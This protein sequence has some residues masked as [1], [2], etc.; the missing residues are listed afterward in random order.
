M[1][2]IFFLIIIFLFS[3]YPNLCEIFYPHFVVDKGKKRILKPSLHCHRFE[4][5]VYMFSLSLNPIICGT[6]SNLN[7]RLRWMSIEILVVKLNLQEKLF[8]GEK[9]GI[10]QGGGIKIRRRHFNGSNCI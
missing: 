4:S 2:R 1:T 8:T 9:T 10:I 3:L 5:N 7:T 6:M